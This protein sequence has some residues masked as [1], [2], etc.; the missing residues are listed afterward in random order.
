MLGG[1]P[2]S[3]QNSETGDLV[4]IKA[5]K[6]LCCQS[7]SLGVWAYHK[8]IRRADRL[9]EL[10][11]RVFLG[12]VAERIVNRHQRPIDIGW[13]NILHHDPMRDSATAQLAS[14]ALNPDA[15]DDLPSFVNK[16]SQ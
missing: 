6:L 9:R 12:S 2:F 8:A 7:L 4:V 13:L 14:R 3:S 16:E 15:N 1:I 11:P 5:H 10:M